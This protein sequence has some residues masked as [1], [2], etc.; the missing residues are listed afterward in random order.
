MQFC[1]WLNS[2]L[3]ITLDI[4]F[5]IRAQF[6]HGFVITCGHHALVVTKYKLR[7]SKRFHR[8]FTQ[9][10]DVEYMVLADVSHILVRT[11]NFTS[12]CKVCT[13]NSQRYY[14]ISHSNTL[15]KSHSSSLK[16]FWCTLRVKVLLNLKKFQKDSLIL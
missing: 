10:Y 1:V 2:E 9:T 7:S 12:D 16:Y 8:G 14:K 3:Q 11:P 4:L 5:T 6:A 13:I 15:K